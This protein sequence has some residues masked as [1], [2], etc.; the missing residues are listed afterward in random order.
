MDVIR[1]PCTRSSGF[2]LVELSIVLVIIGLII[3]GVLVGKDMIEA[4]QLR[5][6]YGQVEKF[7][8]AIYTFRDKYNCLPGDCAVAYTYFFGASCGNNTSAEAVNGCNGNGDG[9]YTFGE[10]HEAWQHLALAGLIAGSYTGGYEAVI[11]PEVSVPSGRMKNTAFS[12]LYSNGLNG[13]GAFTW[14]S[15]GGYGRLNHRN[16]LM[17][18]HWESNWTVYTR[19]VALTPSQAY[20]LD[21][22]YDDGKHYLGLL[23]GDAGVYLDSMGAWQWGACGAGGNTYN[24]GV[25]TP[26]CVFVFDLGI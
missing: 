26:Q 24:T 1:R 23:S 3:G 21:L 18:G 10:G 12:I 11:L 2:T 8:T 4:A 16:I 13:A 17:L 22:K 15:P 20:R 19:G 6:T 14:P 7:K 9:R 25:T 5:A